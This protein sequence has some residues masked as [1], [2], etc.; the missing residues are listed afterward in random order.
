VLTR[1]S[2]EDDGA[3]A[4]DLNIGGIPKLDGALDIGV[5]LSEELPSTSHVMGGVGVED[6]PASLAIVGVVAEERVCS[7]NS[8]RWRKATTVDAA[9]DN[10]MLACARSRA[11][12]SSTYVM[13]AWAHHGYRHSLAQCPSLPLLWQALSHADFWLPAAPPWVPLQP[14][15]LT[16]PRTS[17]WAPLCALRGLPCLRLPIE[18]E[19][20]PFFPS[21]WQAS[22]YS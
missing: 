2:S 7:F 15:C 21:P 22:H 3:D 19:D 12:S 18:E 5:N 14:P 6:P 20:S 13:W 10:L 16:R 1:L 17:A 8:S 9:G 11:G 4:L